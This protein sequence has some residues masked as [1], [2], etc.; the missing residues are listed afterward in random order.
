[1]F[2]WQNLTFDTIPFNQK[3]QLKDKY[4]FIRE[5]SFF[6]IQTTVFKYFTVKMTFKFSYLMKMISLQSLLSVFF[7]IY[8]YFCILLMNKGGIL[9]MNSNRYG[10]S[11][12]EIKNKIKNTE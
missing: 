10:L 9:L 12:T 2:L 3:K 5:K 11:K 8:Y 7:Y 6:I 1:M 4:Y